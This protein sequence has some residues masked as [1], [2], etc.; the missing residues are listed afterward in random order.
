MATLCDLIDLFYV[1]LFLGSGGVV[2]IIFYYLSRV[3]FVVSS[4]VIG[5]LFPMS[6]HTFKTSKKKGV[7]WM[8]KNNIQKFLSGWSLVVIM[9]D[10]LIVRKIVK[11]SRPPFP[12]IFD[13][14]VVVNLEPL[15]SPPVRQYKKSLYTVS[16]SLN[17]NITENGIPLTE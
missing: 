16:F 12:F 11:I 10:S 13:T 3:S 7:R 4:S 17:C 5:L 14:Y 1:F 8:N 9:Y 2:L 6:L 15:F